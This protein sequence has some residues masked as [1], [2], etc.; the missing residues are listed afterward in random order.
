MLKDSYGIDGD[1]SF[2]GLLRI[3]DTIVV[4]FLF[5]PRSISVCSG[6][7]PTGNGPMLSR[8]AEGTATLWTNWTNTDAKRVIWQAFTLTARHDES[9]C[10]K[11][12][13][14]SVSTS[15]VDRRESERFFGL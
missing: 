12:W 9:E 7:L 2:V 15:V 6:L 14:V 8:G 5:L 3:S 11:K 10:E 4:F 1:E 13:R